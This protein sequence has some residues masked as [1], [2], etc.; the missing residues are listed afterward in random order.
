[1]SKFTVTI[2]SDSFEIYGGQAAAISYMNGKSGDLAA[3][4]RAL[5]ADDQARSLVDATRFIDSQ[6]WQGKATGI[7]DGTTVPPGVATTLAWPRSGLTLSD[8]TPVDSTVV[9]PDVNKAAFEL[10]LLVADDPDVINTDNHG[11]NLQTATAGPVSVTYFNAT[12]SANGSATILPGI[13]DRLIGKYLAVS[14]P[15]S[16]SA[17]GGYSGNGGCEST[18][19]RCHDMTR[20]LPY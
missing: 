9:P 2:G 13:L 6:T 4:W 10:A 1:M 3:A 14:D 11:S 16:G 7:V 12:S 8:G 17:E 19:D 20:R 5:D 15:A 18:F